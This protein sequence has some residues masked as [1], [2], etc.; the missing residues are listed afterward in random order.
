MVHPGRQSRSLRFSPDQ[1]L[2]GLDEN[3]NERPSENGISCVHQQ[4][5]MSERR[6]IVMQHVRDI[7]C[8]LQPFVDGL[9]AL[10]LSM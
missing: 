4:S 3:G 5:E 10:S 6:R 8:C 9:S 7:P 1:F 2:A